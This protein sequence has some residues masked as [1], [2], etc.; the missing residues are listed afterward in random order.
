MDISKEILDN[1]TP[2]VVLDENQYEDKIVDVMKSLGKLGKKI[3]YVCLNKPYKDVIEDLNKQN[4]N[5]KD[6]FFI[7]VL[8]SY[9]KKQQPV[10]NCIFI[11]APTDT[12][13]ILAALMKAIK[14]KKCGIVVFDTLST[15]LIYRQ[16]YLILRFVHKILQKK[17]NGKSNK[18]LITLKGGHLMNYERDELIKDVIMFVDNSITIEKKHLINKKDQ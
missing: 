6:F 12:V 4:V 9:Y 11:S 16:T 13:S 10:Y 3:C 17:M 18:V 7:D 1:K 2:L 14:E 8:S 5:V 15:L